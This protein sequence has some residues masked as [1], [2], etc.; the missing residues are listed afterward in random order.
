MVI[1]KNNTTKIKKLNINITKII[2]KMDTTTKDKK[3][4]LIP[5]VHI[6]MKVEKEEE[7]DHPKSNP[8]M[9]T[10]TNKKIQKQKS[11]QSKRRTKKKHKQNKNLLN[12]LPLI[13]SKS[14][15]K[16]Y[17]TNQLVRITNNPKTY[18]LSLKNKRLKLLP[19]PLPLSSASQSL[20]L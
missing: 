5:Q 2:T 19:F 3:Q 12:R 4:K 16:K 7:G 6:L 20:S 10:P 9:K 13:G 17:L 15:F 11:R 1:R 14:T 8:Q 18:L